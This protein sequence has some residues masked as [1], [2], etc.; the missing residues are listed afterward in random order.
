[1]L[2]LLVS[3]KSFSQTDTIV[4]LKEPVAKLVIKDL[5]KGDG[6]GLELKETQQLLFLEQQKIVIKDS[7]IL[8]LESKIKNLD[9]IIGKKDEQFALE[10]EKSESLLKELKSEK[11]KTFLF[12]VG[13]YVGIAATGLLLLQ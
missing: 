1:M 7:I 8:N 10:R 13:T 12:K 2:L 5:I 9:V 3:F 6:I 4:S 11:R